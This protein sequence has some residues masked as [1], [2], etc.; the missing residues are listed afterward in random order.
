MAKRQTQQ[1]QTKQDDSPYEEGFPKT[2]V[3]RDGRERK[4]Y[5]TP[6]QVKA[7][8]DG[9]AAPK[10]EETQLSTTTQTAGDTSG[11]KS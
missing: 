5:N 2:L 10:G 3:H 1:T 6:S 4:V 7:E 11:D 9:F 8:W